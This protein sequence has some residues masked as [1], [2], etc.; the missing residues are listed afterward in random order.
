MRQ[1]GDHRRDSLE[2]EA[3]QRAAVLGQLALA[4]QHVDGDVGLAVDACGEVLSGAG[5]D[6][7]VALDDLGD[8]AA[9][10]LDT[11]RERR[12]VEQEQIVGCG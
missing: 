2:I 8:H 12:D 9:E 7:G 11:Q 3:R 1:A 10:G 5:G 4:L 6:C